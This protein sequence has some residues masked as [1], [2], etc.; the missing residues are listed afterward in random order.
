MLV[1]ETSFGNFGHPKDLMLYMEEES[2][3][4]VHVRVQYCFKDV[5]EKDMSVDDV[6]KWVLA[7]ISP[8]A[9]SIEDAIKWLRI[10]IG[11]IV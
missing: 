9:G 3:T 1:I 10:G 7:Y 11:G 8:I 6:S 5:F 2:I 4:K